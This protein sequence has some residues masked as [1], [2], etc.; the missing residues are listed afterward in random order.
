MLQNQAA[1][2]ASN[3]ILAVKTV[4]I[5][6]KPGVRELQNVRR[7]LEPLGGRLSSHRGAECDL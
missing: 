1:A 6:E 7:R 2:S 4:S 3:P 5:D